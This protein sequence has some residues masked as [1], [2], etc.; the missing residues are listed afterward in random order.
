MLLV[1]FINQNV[2]RYYVKVKS[3]KINELGLRL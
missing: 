1:N 3:P 2:D